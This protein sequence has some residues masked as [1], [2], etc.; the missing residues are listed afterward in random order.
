MAVALAFVNPIDAQIVTERAPRITEAIIHLA[1]VKPAFKRMLLRSSESMLYS[2]IIISIAPIAI[3][4][5]VNHKMLPAF[6]AIPY[7]GIPSLK[8]E[9]GSNNGEDNDAIPF[10]LFS[11]FSQ[12]MATGRTPDNHRPDGEREDDIST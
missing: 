3:L 4:I 12:T 11:I 2:E 7:G 1:Q 5:A 6:V 9:K 8:T 10:D